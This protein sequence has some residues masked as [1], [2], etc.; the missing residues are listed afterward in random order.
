MCKYW[1][2]YLIQQKPAV[3][4]IWTLILA[5]LRAHHSTAELTRYPNYQSICK[6]QGGGQLVKSSSAAAAILSPL[7]DEGLLHAQPLS[8]I[9]WHCRQIFP[10]AKMFCDGFCPAFFWSSSVA[11]SMGF[12]L[13]EIVCPILSHSRH[14]SGPFPFL[15]H[16]DCHQLRELGSFLDCFVGD[17]VLP[18]YV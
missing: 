15:S 4:G 14:V 12:P 7:Q 1:R 2:S 8:A 13:C 5:R 9:L 3:T 10:S 11:L 6:L 18:F 17:T 16:D